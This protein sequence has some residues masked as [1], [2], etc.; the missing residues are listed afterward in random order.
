V[1]RQV[2]SERSIVL[3]VLCTLMPRSR[4][5][6]I[7]SKY[8]EHSDEALRALVSDAMLEAEKRERQEFREL[9]KS[10]LTYWAELPTWS[11]EETAALLLNRDPYSHPI[12]GR[13]QIAIWIEYERRVDMIRRVSQA[14][15]FALPARPSEILA[16]VRKFYPNLVPPELDQA[17]A[18]VRLRRGQEE[19]DPRQRT[20]VMKLLYAL[21]KRLNADS[22]DR[23][24]VNRVAGFCVSAE[25]K[26]S[27]KTVQ[28]LMVEALGH[29]PSKAD[30]KK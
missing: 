28:K 16:G 14:G 2:D 29:R 11:A 25:V 27:E 3:D 5:E 30:A 9:Q 12:V 19:I 13:A 15:E 26:I 6:S 18:A 7:R 8:A 21:L 17:V 1:E 23:G 24:A 20:S 4:P 10:E 22:D